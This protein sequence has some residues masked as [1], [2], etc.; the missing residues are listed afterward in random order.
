[1]GTPPTFRVLLN[2]H[3]RQDHPNCPGS[4][5][6]AMIAPHE[7]RAMSNHGGQSLKVLDRR[8]GLSPLEMVAALEDKP[9]WEVDHL[10]KAQAV[11]RLKALVGEFVWD[12]NGGRCT[13]DVEDQAR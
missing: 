1:M 7:K 8:G 9:F 13:P 12:E 4:V 10:T 11:A 3:Y 6:W 2:Y 5:P